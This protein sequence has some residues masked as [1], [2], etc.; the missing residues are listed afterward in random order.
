MT[1]SPKPN[2]QLV[3][4]SDIK[5]SAA[6]YT[7]LFN[8]KPVTEMDNY[9]AFSAGGEA[10][11]AICSMKKPDADTPRYS[12]IGIMLPSEDDVNR[13]FETCKNEVGAKVVQEPITEPYGRTFVIADP[14]GH[15]IRICLK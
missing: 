12:E 7:K 2:L 5:D 3:Y 6:F 1:I 4:V 15:I 13:F 8:A 10:I 14:D 11:F 9:V